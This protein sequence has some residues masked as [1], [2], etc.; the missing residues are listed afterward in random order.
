MTKPILS[1]F[2]AITILSACDGSTETAD[3]S[4]TDAVAA[5]KAIFEE[6]CAVCHGINL[7]G[8][9]YWQTPNEDGT[10][11]APPLN[12]EGTV[13]QRSD[14]LLFRSIKLGGSAIV[15]SG[16]HSAMPGFGQNLTDEQIWHV[17][18]YIK[19]RWSPMVRARQERMNTK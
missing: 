1:L 5:G 16:F 14:Q 9:P 3:V 11:P 13:W 4:D 12:D 2:A 19:S 18:S 10:V 7:E 8:Q 17:L 15:P 6:R